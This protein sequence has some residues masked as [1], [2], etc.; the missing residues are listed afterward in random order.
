MKAVFR[1]D[2][3]DKDFFKDYL[4]VV[5]TIQDIL[6]TDEEKEQRKKIPQKNKKNS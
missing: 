4:G 2:I 5:D 1:D 6:K 3:L